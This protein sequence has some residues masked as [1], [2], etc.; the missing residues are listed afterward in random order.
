MLA[1]LAAVAAVVAAL[2]GAAQ[3]PLVS[4]VAHG[5]SEASTPWDAPPDRDET[6]HLIFDGVAS[7]LKHWSNTYHR[8]G[9]NVV[10]AF[11]TPGTLLFHGR[12]DAVSP[13]IPEWLSLDAEHSLLFANRGNAGHLFT[14]AATRPLK[15]LYFDGASAYNLQSGT[16]DTQDL[17]IYGNV[18]TGR[19][20]P[21]GRIVDLCEWGKEYEID[22]FLR[23][24]FDFEIMY[25][26]FTSGFEVVSSVNVAPVTWQIPSDS[27]QL[28]HHALPLLTHGE[29]SDPPPPP[30]PMPTGWPEPTGAPGEPPRRRPGGGGPGGPG[31]PGRGPQTPPDPPAGWEGTLRSASQ[32][33][34]EAL[35]A[36][37]WHNFAPLTGIQLDYSGLITFYDPKYS[38]LV[39]ARRTVDDPAL[40]RLL[41]ITREDGALFK[42]ELGEVLTRGDGVRGSGVD[43]GNVMRHIMERY[44]D[45]LEFLRHSL[46]SVDRPTNATTPPVNL[47][48]VVRETRQQV[49]TMLSPY[50]S[51]ESVPASPGGA[52]SENRT[53]LEPAISLCAS[54]YTRYMD[55]STFTPQ[56]HILKSA[57]DAT[58]R[59]ICRT[60]GLVWTTA[61]GAES[62]TSPAAQLTLLK[63]WRAEVERLMRWLDWA[64]WLKCDPA[65][66]PDELCS[67]P[68]WP[69][70]GVRT[71]T[72]DPTPHCLSR[73]HWEGR[74][75]GGGGPGPGGPDGPGGPGGGGRREGGWGRQ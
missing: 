74:G 62:V 31:G 16:L 19:W 48:S 53:W 29:P 52:A 23:M 14:Y 32:A 56:E 12:G 64:V 65:C 58:A 6:G 9:H 7:L 49:L 27:L 30:G 71:G 72:E 5:E 43:W 33:I 45:R 75:R 28:D 41:N 39:E 24:E 18:S 1:R 25:C 4:P 35:Q 63:D 51:R 17:V 22:G 68:Q 34:F 44:A 37:N 2:V 73:L 60:L 26:N 42:R 59:E 20:N 21:F 13:A 67:P 47:T 46:A 15:L 40:Y 10:P 8:N 70:D 11:V 38:S 57:T 50:L 36:G 69:F 55:V 61:F 66:G 54:S 3:V